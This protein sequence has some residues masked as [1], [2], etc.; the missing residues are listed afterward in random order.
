MWNARP[1]NL[2]LPS[3]L[4]WLQIRWLTQK[5]NWTP[6][7]RKLMSK[8][9]RYHA[10]RVMA[11]GVLLAVAACTGRAIRA[12][13]REQSSE[14]LAAEFVNEGIAHSDEMEYDKAIEAYSEAIRLEL[15]IANVYIQRGKA[16]YFKQEYNKAIE[17][18]SQASRLDPK[19]ANAYDNVAWVL[20]TC[21]E[22]GLRDGKRA[23][24]LATK[25]CELSQWKDGS[26]LDTLAAAYAESGDFKEAVKWQKEALQMGC[27]YKKDTEKA[28][29][30]LKLFEGGKPYRGE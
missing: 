9:S 5:K 24:E 12:Q 30:R 17:D 2:Q 18:Y 25:A 4:Q 7:Q 26:I 11:V 29:K 23:I 28:E 20:A 14:N 13:V 19:N 10:V 27:D 6:P 8:A 1:D 16:Y 22:D 3:L 15:K 21:P